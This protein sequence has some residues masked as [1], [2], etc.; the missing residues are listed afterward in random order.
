MPGGDRAW[1]TAF[2]V[3]YVSPVPVFVA[4][5]DIGDVSRERAAFWAAVAW[6]AGQLVLFFVCGAVA[7]WW[8]RRTD[9]TTPPPASPGRPRA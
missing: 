4:L 8:L 2:G 9:A 3:V 5:H 6:V 1:M 7:L